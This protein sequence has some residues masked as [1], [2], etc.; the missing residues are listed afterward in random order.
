M[1]SFFVCFF[2]FGG[3]CCCFFFFSFFVY[4]RRLELFSVPK[5]AFLFQSPWP[6]RALLLLE[7]SELVLCFPDS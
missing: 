6:L 3:F 2:L 4:F 1:C 7:R 5:V